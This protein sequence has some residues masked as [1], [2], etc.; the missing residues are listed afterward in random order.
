VRWAIWAVAD[1]LLLVVLDRVAVWAESRGWLYWRHRAPATTPGGSG[2]LADLLQ[3]FQPAQRHV[4]AERDRQRL[5]ADQ[6]ESAAPPFGVDLDRGVVRLPATDATNRP[7]R[8]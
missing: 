1:L 8:V 2:I 5:T 4:V 3:V 6:Q 7:P